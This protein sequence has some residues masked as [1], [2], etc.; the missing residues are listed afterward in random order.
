MKVEIRQE[1]VI[2]IKKI[3]GDDEHF[4]N[5]LEVLANLLIKDEIKR[6]EQEDKLNENTYLYYYYLEHLNPHEQEGS[7]K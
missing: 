5:K 3:V 2:K 7:K 1:L 6:H 4:K